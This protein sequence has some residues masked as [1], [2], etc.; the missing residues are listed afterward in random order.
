M[1]DPVS[2]EC[3]IPPRVDS[4]RVPRLHD[5][6]VDLIVLDGHVIAPVQNRGVRTIM[7]QIIF[8]RH[9]DACHMNRRLIAPGPLAQPVHMVVADSE[10]RR[11]QRQTIS[12]DSLHPTVTAVMESRV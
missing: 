9:P 10:I 3:I 1:A 7:D 6:T 12:A 8:R 4:A 11:L 5:D 2:T